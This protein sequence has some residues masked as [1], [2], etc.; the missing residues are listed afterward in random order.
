[1]GETTGLR[2]RKRA[3]TRAAIIRAATDLF[4]DRGFTATSATDIAN[5]A[6][7][8][9]RTFFL[10]FP[11]KEDVLFHHLEAHIQSA[12]GTLD[13]LGSGATPWDSVQ[14]AAL[15]L[16][17]AFDTAT[18]RSD[19][20]ADVRADVVR[21]AR[22][23]PGS[24]MLRLQSAYT[25]LLESLRERFADPALWPVLATHLGACLGA[26]VAAAV[27]TPP[28]ERATAMRAAIRRA[29]AGFAE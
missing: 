24:L 20:L 21:S 8:S 5:A 25:R 11:A 26:A 28:A 19:E 2:D 14:A 6:G 7:V 23:I 1:M 29:G 3:E 13:R 4:L 22:G 27:S 15:A 9:R 17:D 10:Y 16:V 12:V 18:D